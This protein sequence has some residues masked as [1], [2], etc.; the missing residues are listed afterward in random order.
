MATGFSGG[1][2]SGELQLGNQRAAMRRRLMR[3][4]FAA[5][6]LAAACSD[7]QGTHPEGA[8]QLFLNAARSGD[9]AIVYQRLGPRTRARLAGLQ[10]ATR[11]TAG[12]LAMKPEDFL[13]VG[14]APPAW[15]PAGTRTLRR[16]DA[17]AQVEVYSPAGDRHTVDLV[18]EGKEWK[19]ELPGK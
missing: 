19:I 17:T 14:W 10:D 13:S 6:A 7:S 9:R 8:V 11:R 16:D 18:R 4:I 15:E 1:Q 12:R 3:P 5:L 2:R